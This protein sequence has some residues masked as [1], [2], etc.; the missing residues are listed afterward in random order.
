MEPS[1]VY[2]T[3]GNFNSQP[4][5]EAD[6]MMLTW[7]ISRLY[8][9][10]QPRKEADKAASYQDTE[11]EIISIHSLARRLTAIFNNY[12]IYFSIIIVIFHIILSLIYLK[13]HFLLIDKRK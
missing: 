9:N 13:N 11:D 6:F 4:R 3:P 7:L 12:I 2:K 1:T 10:S 5:K 8:F